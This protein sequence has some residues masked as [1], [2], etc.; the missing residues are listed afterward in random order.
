M[1]NGNKKKS[2]QL[3]MPHGTACNKLR[4]NILFDLLCKLDYNVCYKCDDQ[5][6]NV[7]DLSIEHIKPWLDSNSPIE[8]FFDLENIAFSHSSCNTRG[9]AI[10]TKTNEPRG[11][12]WCWNCKEYKPKDE[13]PPCKTQK[14]GIRCTECNTKRMRK[15]RKK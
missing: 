1:N 6:E 8:L 2:E 9:Q 7:D 14:K 5:I 11:L 15:Y 13:F 12:Y 4:K 3:G 10:H